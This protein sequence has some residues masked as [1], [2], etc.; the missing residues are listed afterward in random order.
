MNPIN[1][2]E[3]VDTKSVVD[4]FGVAVSALC[5]GVWCGL[6]R[7]LR[8]DDL[9]SFVFDFNCGNESIC[10]I[11]GIDG[12]NSPLNGTNCGVFRTNCSIFDKPAF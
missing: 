3:F 12:G 7:F 1:K 5:S 11:S 4:L 8:G 6:R 2:I 9:I 10:T